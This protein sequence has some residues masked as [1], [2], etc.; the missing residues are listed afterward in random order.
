MSESEKK[1]ERASEK[2]R[3]HMRQIGEAKRRFAR[4][5]KPPASL[6]EMFARMEEI[7]ARLG[8]FAKPGV[9]GGERELGSSLAYSQRRGA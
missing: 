7:E 4:E 3:E 9:P 5:S 8:E 1:P 2:D 6:A